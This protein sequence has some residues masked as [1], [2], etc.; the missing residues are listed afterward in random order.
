MVWSHNLQNQTSLAYR[1][2]ERGW[3]S[4]RLSVMVSKRNLGL[5]VGVTKKEIMNKVGIEEGN[6]EVGKA[7]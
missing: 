7:E 6:V 4:G 3:S 1:A 2:P 5:N